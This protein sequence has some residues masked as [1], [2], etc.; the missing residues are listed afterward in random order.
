MIFS[1]ETVPAVFWAAVP[2]IFV[3]N[4]ID[5]CIDIIYTKYHQTNWK[6]LYITVNNDSTMCTLC[7]FFCGGGWE[8]GGTIPATF[9]RRTLAML[10]KSDPFVFWVATFH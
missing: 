3:S 7:F 6:F 9:L 4:A 1:L 10:L 5:V 2:T 8:G